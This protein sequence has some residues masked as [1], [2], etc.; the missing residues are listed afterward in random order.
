MRGRAFSVLGASALLALGTLSALIRQPPPDVAWLLYVAERVLAGDRLGIDLIEVNPP[1]VVWLSAGPASVARW[2]GL[3]P[4]STAVMAG[5]GLVTVSAWL[6]R[7]FVT[8]YDMPDR[9]RRGM[10]LAGVFVLTV[11]PG[12]DFLQREHLAVV[13]LLP[14]LALAA[15]RVDRGEARLAPAAITGAL[16]AIGLALKPYFLLPWLAVEAFVLFRRRSLEGRP[17]LVAVLGVG[18]SI[19]LAVVL[20]APAWLPSV[21]PLAGLYGRYLRS[22]WFLNLAPTPAVLVPALGLAV[23]VAGWRLRGHLTGVQAVTALATVGFWVGAVVQGKGFP[24]HYFPAVGFGFLA[25]V[26]ATRVRVPPGPASVL[27]VLLDGG[28]VVA[29]LM[30]LAVTGWLATTVLGRTR[31]PYL[32]DGYAALRV[33][34]AD[35]PPEAT[36]VVLSSNLASGWPLTSDLGATWG[37]RYPSLWPLAAF[38]DALA[39]GPGLITPRPLEARSP[40]ERRFTEDVVSDLVRSRPLFVLVL[41]TDPTADHWGGATRFDYVQ[42]LAEDPRFTPWLSGYRVVTEVSRYRVLRRADQGPPP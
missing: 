1:I 15:V 17:E 32:G 28:R 38:Y 25:L 10:V 5:I 14:Y 11:L 29:W 41:M 24:Y 20:L 2:L 3:S 42:Y 23:T 8:R 27:R 21:L 31:P 30:P 36:L 7:A 18:L 40:R 12:W 4:W 9:A 39:P 6:T 33:A 37:L 19:G 16:A 22:P 35:T 13:G 34:L 26:A